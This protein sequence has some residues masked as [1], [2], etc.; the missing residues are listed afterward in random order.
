M[1]A[2]NGDSAG[3]L[4]TVVFHL[5]FK[6]EG[7]EWGN[8]PNVTDTYNKIRNLTNYQV[9]VLP[10]YEGNTNS[11]A[12]LA[13]LANL[14]VPLILPVFEGGTQEA[15]TLKLTTDEIRQAIATCDV[16]M[17]RLQEIISWH[18]EHNQSFP[19]DYVKTVLGFC[20]QNNLGVM[21]SEWK[22]D[23]FPTLKDCIA[24]YED[25]V[26]VMYQTNDEF[27]EPVEGYMMAS[28]MFVHWG[29]SVQPWYWTSR[30]NVE[31][32]NMPISLLAWHAVLAKNMGAEILQ[33]E[34]SWYF[35]DN[36]GEPNESMEVIEEMVG[37]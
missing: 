8:T 2:I 18:I 20:R 30:Y 15:P 1:G 4:K 7:Y 31:P 37:R 23:G 11:S 5:S 25:M 22:T 29:A 32:T 33:F 35:F 36:N 24:G 3:E 34:P 16:R 9:I 14:T 27:H 26:T 6:G 10:E 13:W 19:T 12:M 28:N 17:V 21:W